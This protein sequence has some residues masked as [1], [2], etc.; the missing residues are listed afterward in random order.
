MII[1][2]LAFINTKNNKGEISVINEYES[3]K[4]N[5]TNIG[6]YE[7]Y[8]N[9]LLNWSN[10]LGNI[11]INMINYEPKLTDHFTIF[12]VI[13]GNIIAINK[14]SGEFILLN[15]LFGVNK[16]FFYEDNNNKFI[17]CD[18]YQKLVSF[19]SNYEINLDIK[20]LLD[21]VLF[22]Y[23]IKSRTFINKIKQLEGGSCIKFFGGSLEVTKLSSS[24]KLLKAKRKLSSDYLSG[25]LMLFWN[26]S[27]SRKE[28]FSRPW[29]LA[30]T[31]TAFISDWWD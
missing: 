3:S 27:F 7:F 15:D 23:P 13:K 30:Y 19:V 1:T 18:N 2:N 11:I 29:F 12:N 4:Y 14:I 6:E 8:Y 5:I 10:T 26:F 25:S 17:I 16:I 9:R 31:L 22:S 24:S 20:S 28:H 21:I